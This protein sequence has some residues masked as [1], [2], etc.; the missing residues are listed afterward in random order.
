MTNT[1]FASKPT[2]VVS[3]ALSNKLAGLFARSA[4]MG[5]LT[6]ATVTQLD[7][8]AVKRLVLSLQRHGIAGG[9]GTALSPLVHDDGTPLSAAAASALERRIDQ[10]AEALEASAAPAAEWPA[11]RAVFGDE[12][13]ADLLDVS[14]SSLRRYGAGERDTPDTVAGRLHWLALTV[15]DLAGAYNNFGM[16]RW[17]ERPRAQ[18]GGQSPRA[19]LGR[20]WH[21]DGAAA[22]R[23][24]QLAASL[25]GAQPL[26]V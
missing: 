22:G 15:A 19:L 23:V 11:M 8:A 7:A 3:P 18:L 21:V 26:A 6:G 14:L 12:V 4:A 17:F 13:L 2:A 10:V 25:S 9:A 5:L 1:H 16:R 24:R 20:D